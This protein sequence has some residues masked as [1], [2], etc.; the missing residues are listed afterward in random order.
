MRAHRYSRKAVNR[1]VLAA[2]EAALYAA[3][4][5]AGP[6]CQRVDPRV[7]QPWSETWQSVVG[8][9]HLLAF[10]ASR[11]HLFK[12]VLAAAAGDPKRAPPRNGLHTGVLEVT[13]TKAAAAS[14][15]G[16]AA[17]L[18]TAVCAADAATLTVAE[19][20]R[21]CV[22]YVGSPERGGAE[23]DEEDNEEAGKKV[24][25]EAGGSEPAAAE[26]GAAAQAWWLEVLQGHWVRADPDPAAAEVGGVDSS[27]ASEP[28]PAAEELAVRVKVI[29]QWEFHWR[30]GA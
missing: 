18:F 23:E 19:L 21:C 7:P 2:P 9:R 6:L 11:P 20:V 1:V 10:V 28:L 27:F 5:C 15:D 30:G 29:N 22:S 13:E 8:M 12:V 14:V 17:A 26:E 16:A 25:T 4:S 24:E 3:A